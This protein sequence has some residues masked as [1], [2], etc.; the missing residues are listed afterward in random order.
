MA[1]KSV[2]LGTDRPVR[3]TV[4]QN[5]AGV[6]FSAATRMVATFR[7]S[8]VVA[9]TSVDNTLIDY[10]AGSGVV[11]FSFGGLSVPAGTY[12]VSL[13]VYDAA[14]PLGQPVIHPNAAGELLQLQFINSVADTVL[15]IQSDDGLTVNANAYDSAANLLAY[16]LAR[17]N[18]VDYDVEQIERAIV[19]ATDYVDV[20][21]RYK[22]RRLNGRDQS[23][24]WP[25]VRV[26]DAQGY[27]VNGVPTEVKEAVFEYALRALKGT[28]NPD[29]VVED[30][31]RQLESKTEKFGPFSESTSYYEAGT[32]LPKYPEADK[33][34]T[35][36]GLTITGGDIIRG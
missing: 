27:Y 21:F 26:N 24:E 7:G 28:L 30:L 8:A 22:G 32:A 12:A 1:I 10:S 31:G 15:L 16:H 5:G 19:K 2:Y 4:L 11:D 35:S 3:I 34:L 33:K 18:A 17:G 25:R 29:P 20:R 14:H 9:D 6:D 23:T 36:A 13:T